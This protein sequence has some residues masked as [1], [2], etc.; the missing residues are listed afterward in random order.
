MTIN[1][2]KISNPC[3]SNYCTVSNRLVLSKVFCNKYID[4]K[5]DTKLVIQLVILMFV[6][7]EN[8]T[9]TSGERTN[10]KAGLFGFFFFFW[11][12]CVPQRK[13]EVWKRKKT[14]LERTVAGAVGLCNRCNKYNSQTTAFQKAH[15]KSSSVIH[16]RIFWF[17]FLFL[18]C[19][20]LAL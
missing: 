1:W 18:L 11:F 2:T 13:M 5:F 16:L 9:F 20:V 15:K 8:L 4:I 19:F 3:K 7:H 17:S 14:W 6:S 10:I 12:R